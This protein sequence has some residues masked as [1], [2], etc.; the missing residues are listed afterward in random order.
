MPLR[1]ILGVLRNSYCRTVGV[2]YMHITDPEEREWLQQRI[3][4]K[5]DQPDR[6]KQKHVLGRLN[7]AEAFETFLQTKYVGQKRF[8]LEGGESVIPLLDEVLIAATDHGLDEVAIGMPHRGRLNVLANVL[9]K[10]YAKIFGEF[11]GNIDPGT[12]QGS[13]DV[14]YHLGADGHASSTR[15]AD[16]EIAV[17]LASNPSHLETVNPV[18]EGIV[19]AKQDMI[20]KGEERLHRAAGPAARRLR[21][22][23]PGRGR[24]DAEP[25]PAARLPHRRHGARRRQQPG[26]L[27]HQPGRGPVE[28]LLDRRRPDD[29]RADL[30]R[31]RRRPRGLR[32]GGPAGRR[33]PA[34][35]QEGRRHRPGLLPPS[36]AQRGRRPVDDPAADVRH[37]RPQALGPEAVHRGAGRPRRHHARGGRGG[38]ARTT[39]GSSSG[40]S[41]RPT[42]RRTPPS[43]SR[44]WTRARRSESQVD[45]AITPEV[46]QADRR[47]ARLLP[48]GLHPAPEAASRC[49]SGAR[50]WPAR[51]ASTGP[52]A[53]CSPS[54]RCSWRASRSGWPARTP[55]AAPS[56]SGTRCSSTGR[57]APSTR[58]WPTSTEDQA[59]FFVYDSL[60]SEYAALGFEYGYSVAN[61]KALVLWEAQFGDFVDGAQMVIDEFISSGEAKWG[62]RSGV[63]ML[64]P[65]GLEG[66]GPDHSSGRIERF[67]QLSAENNMTVANCTTPGNYFHLLRRQALSDVHRPL[68]VFTPKSLLRAKAAVSPVEDFTDAGL[69][70]GAARPGRGRRAAGRLGRAPGAAV[71]RQGRL[72]PA[73]PSARPRAPPTSR[74]CGSSSSTRCRPSRSSSALEQY[75]NADRRRLGAGGAGEH[76]R[77]AVHGRQPARAPARGPHAAPGQPARRRPARPSGRPRC[78][79]SSSA[80]WS[81][82]PSPTERLGADRVLHRPRASRSWPT[83]GA[84]SR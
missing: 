4:V 19:R 50:R 28:P 43:P 54:A 72:R 32:A 57:P 9:G 29:Q 63:V 8:S 81:P 53:S 2:E 51:A 38:A 75:P 47:R 79:R 6:E 40:P 56:C 14:K 65:H 67:L 3:E 27:H 52:W 21:V 44:S 49:S 73:W 68:V 41:P 5:H 22:R 17:S 42:T 70:P 80:S 77:L 10:S 46:A 11:E 37:H 45:T 71:Q 84:R 60:L 69:P 39:A 31:E 62:Q 78:T 26:R 34:G 74:S 30:P 7:A 66:Q 23:R 20:D 55:A 36:R 1:D 24:R 59:K 76:G 83:G 12:V 18:L 35:V 82:R 48:A 25:L 13:G 16:A 61:P 15:T 58:R 64:L 33:V